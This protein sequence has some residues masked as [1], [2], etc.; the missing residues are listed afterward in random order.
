MPQGTPGC[1]TT[2]VDQNLDHV[3]GFAKVFRKVWDHPYW[4]DAERFRAWID[5]ILLARWRG[6]FVMWRGRRVFVSRGAFRASE[7]ELVERWGR[8][9]NWVR[10]FLA[11]G[12]KYGELGIKRDHS[13]VQITLLNYERYHGTGTSEGT[14][15]GPPKDHPRTTQGPPLYIEEVQDVEEVQETP[16]AIVDNSVDNPSMPRM[17]AE[18]VEAFQQASGTN[19]K[20]PSVPD[21]LAVEKAIKANG[22]DHIPIRECVRKA[23]A[24]GVAY[25]KQSRSD[26]PRSVRYGLAAWKR[27]NERGPDPREQDRREPESR[28]LHPAYHERVEP[29]PTRLMTDEESRRGV[30][31][32][33]D[34]IKTVL[35]P[36]RSRK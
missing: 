27:R 3:G 35:R 23:T 36:D 7:R 16:V 1:P 30:S 26:P 13:G 5:C 20:P 15:Q 31:H 24:E 9:R 8:S 2:T 10:L 34:L 6:G 18:V 25:A 29:V 21:K 17:V 28:P 12:E 4:Q 32:V 14:T 11:E 33:R 19:P 22:G